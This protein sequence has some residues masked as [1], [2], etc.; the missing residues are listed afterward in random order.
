MVPFELA[1]EAVGFHQSDRNRPNRGE[2]PSMAQR[3]ENY[4]VYTE[5]QVYLWLRSSFS[6]AWSSGRMRR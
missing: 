5:W 2:L 6:K 3:H 1:L 4:V